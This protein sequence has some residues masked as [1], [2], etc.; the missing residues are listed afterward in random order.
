MSELFADIVDELL[1]GHRFFFVR[2]CFY[3]LWFKSEQ[4]KD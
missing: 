4:V 2:G 3:V 1:V